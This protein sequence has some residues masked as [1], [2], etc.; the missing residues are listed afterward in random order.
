MVA[1]QIKSCDH[2]AKFFNESGNRFGNEHFFFSGQ[3]KNQRIRP[4]SK[5]SALANF[6][7]DHSL[8]SSAVV[9]GGY[10]VKSAYG[11]ESLVC[12]SIQTSEKFQKNKRRPPT[13]DAF[14]LPIL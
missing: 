11:H 9:N 7:V 5:E 12:T 4:Y 2:Q 3:W 13:M 14:L 6:I 10:N 8:R 1:T